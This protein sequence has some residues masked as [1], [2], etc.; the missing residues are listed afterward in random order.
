MFSPSYFNERAA[1]LESLAK[2]ITDLATRTMCLDLARRF[3]VIAQ[4]KNMPNTQPDI[5]VERL[6]ERMGGQNP[7]PG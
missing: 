4:M 6:A 5:E 7:E 1:E 3:R 2:G